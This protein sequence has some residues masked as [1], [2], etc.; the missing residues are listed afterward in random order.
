MRKLSVKA[1]QGAFRNGDKNEEIIIDNVNGN[2]ARRS[3]SMRR[4]G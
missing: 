4:Q 3:G 1:K 2:H